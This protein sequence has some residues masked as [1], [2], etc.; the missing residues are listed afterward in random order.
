MSNSN[1]DGRPGM[2]GGRAAALSIGS[3]ARETG[4]K[5]QTIRYYEQIGLLPAPARTAGNQ[6]VYGKSHRD[7]L[8]TRPP[9]VRPPTIS[10]ATSWRRWKRAS[11]GWR[12]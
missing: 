7:R 1:P 12:R 6:R 2:T 8:A 3:L 5:V 10:P 4:A 9:L 11:A